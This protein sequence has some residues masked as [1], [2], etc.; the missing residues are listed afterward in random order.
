MPLVQRARRDS[1]RGCAVGVEN[2]G[3]RVTKIER[4]LLL[5]PI[6]ALAVWRAVRYLKLATRA[7]PIRASQTA[8]WS[9]N[10]PGG[11]TPAASLPRAVR[12]ASLVAAVALWVSGNVV[13]WLVLFR[14]PFES[15][16]PILWPAFVDIF[17][18]FYLIQFAGRGGRIWA[19]RFQPDASAVQN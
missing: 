17:L 5:I 12:L 19:R 6:L 9:A 16:I 14:L 13:L 3:S 4:L 2:G 8:G 7:R 18:N 10:A 11:E 15:N 1:R